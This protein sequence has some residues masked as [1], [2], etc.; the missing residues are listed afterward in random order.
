MKKKNKYYSEIVALLICTFFLSSE[1]IASEKLDFLSLKNSQ[2]NL[3]LGPSFEYPVKLIYKKK[4]LPLIILDKSYTWRKMMDFENNLGWIH[5]SQLS[6]RK[7]ALNITNN[8]ILYKKSTIYSK[9][10]AKIESGRL[11]LIKKCNPEWCKIKTGKFTGWVVKKSL[12]GNT[13]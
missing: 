2:V 7:T 3:R 9:P 5:I 12:W 6:P 10:L 1:S 11:V 4:F 13:K 8:S